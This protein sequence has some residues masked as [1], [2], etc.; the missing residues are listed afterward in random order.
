[1]CDGIQD[2]GNL[3]AI[4]RT[5]SAFGADYVLLMTKTVDVY[6]PKIVRASSGTLLDIPSG[7][8]DEDDVI[9]MKEKGYKL[10]VSDVAKKSAVSIKN[11]TRKKRLM[12]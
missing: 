4:M 7:E 1:M 9:D 12:F 8:C 3:G 10:Y 11:M 6:N 2:P 5:S